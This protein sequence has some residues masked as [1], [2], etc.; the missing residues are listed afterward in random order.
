M[1]SITIP[2]PE[3][4]LLR[5]Q[6]LAARLKT[7]PEELASVGVEEILSRSDE[8]FERVVDY[9]LNKNAELYRRLA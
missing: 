6:E 4:H 8:D 9:V 5:L 3:E 7:T 1:T 2:I